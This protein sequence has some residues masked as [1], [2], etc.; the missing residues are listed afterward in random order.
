MVIAVLFHIV[1]F[2]IAFDDK[3]LNNKILFS[4][5]SKIFTKAGPLKT[6]LHA[7]SEYINTLM[8]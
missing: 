6:V 4:L 7:E 8:I 2:D 3:I 5:N 1:V